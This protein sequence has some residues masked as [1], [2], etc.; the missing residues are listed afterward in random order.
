MSQLLLASQR[1][2]SEKME[3][4]GFEFEFKNVHRAIADLLA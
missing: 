2:S 3:A 4:L 1:V